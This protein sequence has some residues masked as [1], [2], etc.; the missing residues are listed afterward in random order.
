MKKALIIILF[1]FVLTQLEEEEEER[2]PNIPHNP[3][4]EPIKK[5]SL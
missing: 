4:P 3:Y 2:T 1:T 5:R